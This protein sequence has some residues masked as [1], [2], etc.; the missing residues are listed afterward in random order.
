M[1]HRQR[2]E[3]KLPQDADG[4]FPFSFSLLNIIV[5]EASRQSLRT[6]P[7][8]NPNLWGMQFVVF[9]IHLRESR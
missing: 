4:F 1:H 9:L 7:I 6:E 5:L 8:V 3:E 2:I